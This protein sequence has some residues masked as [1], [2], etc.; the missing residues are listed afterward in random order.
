MA[1]YFFFLQLAVGLLAFL[2]PVPLTTTG[3]GFGRLIALIALGAL[4]FSSLLALRMDLQKRHAPGT[5]FYASLGAFLACFLYVGLLAGRD[6]RKHQAGLVIA[7]LGSAAAL[8]ASLLSAPR[9]PITLGNALLSALLLGAITDAMIL[10]HWYIV[11]PKMTLVPLERLTLSFM[12]LVVLRA[13]FVTLL[14]QPTWPIGL[15][16]HPE[17]LWP[18]L[19]TIQRLAVG[20]VVP[21]VFA[22]MIWKTAKIRSTQSATG[23]LYVANVFVFVGELISTYMTYSL[24]RIC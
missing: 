22:I 24:G 10:G 18:A 11:L 16:L 15:D 14:G 23:I 17:R 8:A 1:G 9:L 20:L 5:L 2:F 6:R 3:K 21:F 12:V 13:L 19:F 7:A 4:L